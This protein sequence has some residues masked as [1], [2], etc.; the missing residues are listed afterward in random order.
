MVEKMIHRKKA[1]Y[2]KN[3]RLHVKCF[4]SPKKLCD[5]VNARNNIEV[6]QIST[7]GHSGYYHYLWFRVD[8]DV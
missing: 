3:S 7:Y 1:I 4:T 8:E 5:W 2:M 6:V